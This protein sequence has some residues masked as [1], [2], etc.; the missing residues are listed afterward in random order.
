[1]ALALAGV[2]RQ[3][4][5]GFSYSW[6]ISVRLLLIEHAQVLRIGEELN[7]KY[8]ELAAGH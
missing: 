6:A 3:R 4:H 1:V 8:A 7:G 5:G 2:D